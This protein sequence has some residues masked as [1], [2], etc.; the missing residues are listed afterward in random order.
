MAAPIPIA[1]KKKMGRTAHRRIPDEI[2]TPDGMPTPPIYLDDYALEEWYRLCDGLH[3]MGVLSVVDQGAFAACCEAYSDWRHA[4]EE[5]N[6]VKKEQSVL[7]SMVQY[8][9]NG[10]QI[11]Q[12]LIGVKNVARDKYLDACKQFGMTPL[13]RAKMAMAGLKEGEGSK[14]KGLIAQKVAN[15]S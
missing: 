10:N 6:K 14:F 13:A 3:H 8:T 1:I 15:G 2:V 11:Q 9:H 4:S 5:I 12:T 7:D